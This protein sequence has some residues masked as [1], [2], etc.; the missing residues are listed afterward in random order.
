MVTDHIFTYCWEMIERFYH[1]KKDD[2]DSQV[3]ALENFCAGSGLAVDDW[4]SEIG[5]GMNFKRKEFL[6]LIEDITAGRISKLVI[7][8]KD[9]L[10]R[11]GFVLIEKLAIDNGCE[12]IIMNQ[13][14]MSPQQ[15]MVEDLLA[16][17]HTFSCRLYGLRKYKN[18]IKED[19]S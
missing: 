8:H 10:V 18:K 3:K 13:E 11:F 1:G 9:R 16:I 2:L 5:G 17:V 7:A 6:N 14:S 15:E 19:L 12:V 4:V